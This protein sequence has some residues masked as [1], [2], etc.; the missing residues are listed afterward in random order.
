MTLGELASKLKD[1]EIAKS[2][3]TH[4]E[5]KLSLASTPRQ[6]L[7][8]QHALVEATSRFFQLEEEVLP[9]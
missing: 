5:W 7:Q 3:V 8:A 2:S 4:A 6:H 1:L 9:L